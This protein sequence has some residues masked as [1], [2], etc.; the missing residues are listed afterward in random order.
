MS[1]APDSLTASSRIQARVSAEGF[2]WPDIHGV[3]DKIREEIS[4]LEEALKRGDLTH[5][6]RELG[7]LLFV[8]VNLAR[9]LD[10]DP[11][12]ELHRANKK[13]LSRYTRLKE[14]VHRRKR[15]MKDLSFQE[16]NGIWEEVKRSL[17]DAETR[18]LT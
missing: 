17:N 12:H 3:I 10:T 13:F 8:T 6:R 7:D 15:K 16:L 18:G 1:K 11:S 9:F 2:D 5:A 4:E 14:T